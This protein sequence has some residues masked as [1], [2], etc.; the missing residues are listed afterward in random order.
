[1]IFAQK[2]NNRF[3]YKG[4]KYGNGQGQ[5]HRSGEFEYRYPQNNHD[6]EH[7]FAGAEALKLV[8]YVHKASI[9]QKASFVS[10]GGSKNQEAL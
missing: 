6:E 4:Q 3:Q 2:T 8:R 10:A 7:A 1:V 9:A 5:K